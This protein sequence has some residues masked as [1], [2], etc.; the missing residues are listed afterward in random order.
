MATILPFMQ[1][2]VPFMV[3]MLPFLGADLAVRWTR[4]LPAHH[5]YHPGVE[6]EGE[7][8]LQ[9]CTGIAYKP[10]CSVRDVQY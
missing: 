8:S 4:D 1:A 6:E 5:I 3:T 7:G 2:I 10:T 9:V